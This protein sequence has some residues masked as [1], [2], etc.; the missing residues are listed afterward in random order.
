MQNMV[1]V[2]VNIKQLF[3]Y[4]AHIPACMH[5]QTPHTFT[6]TQHTHNTHLHTQAHVCKHTYKHIWAHTNTRAHTHT[7]QERAPCAHL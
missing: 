7:Q 4:S 2:S 6:G 5:T 3:S 1:K